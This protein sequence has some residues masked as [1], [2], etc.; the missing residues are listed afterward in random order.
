MAYPVEDV[1]K[2]YL[3][4]DAMSPKKLQKILYYAYSWYLTMQNED[5]EELNDTLFTNKFQAWVHGPVIRS[6]YGTYRDNGYQTIT[7]HTG[8]L[9]ELDEETK[10]VL[11]QVWEVYGS[12]TGN[13]LESISHQE[14]PWQKAREGYQPLDRCEVEISDKDIF[15]CY[16]QRIQ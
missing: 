9:P 3:A 5:A 10:D 6:V 13:E 4:K 15:E 16:V 14:S 2:Y 7:K 8:D 11:D 12:Y 1:I